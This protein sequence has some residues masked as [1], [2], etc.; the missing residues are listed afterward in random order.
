MNFALCKKHSV[1]KAQM[2]IIGLVVIVILLTLGLLFLAIFKLK[3][4]DGSRKVFLGQGYATSALSALMKTT[5]SPNENCAGEA[6]TLR[7]QPRLGADILEDCAIYFSEYCD[8]D[9]SPPPQSRR[10]PLSACYLKKEQRSNTY[11][12]AYSDYRC[13]LEEGGVAQA[14]HSCAFFQEKSRQLLEKTLGKWGRKYEF[15]V[16]LQTEA[17]NP[18]ILIYFT[19]KGGCPGERESS[20]IFPLQTDA[21]EVIGELWVC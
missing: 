5:V 15:Q 1:K 21:G 10:P 17:P 4:D 11:K 2:E 3:D 8:L 7:D 18:Y 9:A 12:E 19:G 20:G 6:V 14:K 16:R 13:R